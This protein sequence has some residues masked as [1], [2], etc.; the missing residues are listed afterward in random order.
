[1]R[2]LEAQLQQRRQ[3]GLY[4]SRRIQEGMQG[5]ELVLDGQPCLAFCS[6]DYLG[7][8][9]HPEVIRASQ[10]GAQ[11]F[12]A[13]SAAS[14]LING[15]ARIHHQLEEALAEFVQRQRALLFSTGY[16]ANLGVMGALLRRGDQ[17][18]EDRLNHASLIDAGLLSGARFSRYAHADVDDLKHKLERECAGERLVASDGVFSMDGD[19]APLPDMAIACRDK[20]AW[21]M[22]DDAHGLGVLGKQGRGSLEHFGLSQTDVPILMGTLGKAFGSFGAFVAGSEALIETLI[23]QARSY[24]YTTALPPSVAAASLASLT[25]VQQDSWRREKLNAHI[26]T[27]R[28]GAR[29]LGLPLMNSS[30]AIQPVL[31]GGSERALRWSELL[32]EQGIYVPAIRPP[33]VEKGAARLRICLNAEHQTQHI[34][35]LLDALDSLLSST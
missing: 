35:R 30:T 4:R 18:L 17:V 29:Q 14:H 24:I 2:D 34:E 8:A 19:M 1:M 11:T 5:V 7:L 6:N 25:L 16:M 20:D 32:W 12:G 9:H 13:G 28:R 23:N 15:H 22:V 27:F 21:L 33:T 3:Q 26:E 31:L 10:S